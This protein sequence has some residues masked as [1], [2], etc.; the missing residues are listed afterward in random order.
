MRNKKYSQF[1]KNELDKGYHFMK[2][3]L[4]D[5]PLWLCR[6]F[7]F[8][9]QD[10]KN[11]NFSYDGATFSVER[12]KDTLFEIAAFLHDW[13]NSFGIVSYI[14]DAFMLYVM[15]LLKY[16]WNLRLGRYLKTRLTF[17]NVLRHKYN[18]T[19]KGKFPIELLN[20][21]RFYSR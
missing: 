9:W 7:D 21:E 2:S 12:S 3:E 18:G 16:R 1:T 6:L 15:K 20:N 4:N 8:A 13:L 17:L 19:Y 5:A 10:F 11:G 14:A